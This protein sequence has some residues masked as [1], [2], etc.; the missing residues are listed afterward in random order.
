MFLSEI[1]RAL[2]R[3]WYVV[4]VGLCCTIALMALAVKVTP[5]EYSVAAETLLLPPPTSVPVGEN[6]YLSLGGLN[7]VGDILARAMEDAPAT[8]AMVAAG[9]SSEFTF[10]RDANSAAPM[11]LLTV[12]GESDAEAVRNTDVILAQ[13]PMTLK[14][15]QAR[16]KVPDNSFVTSTVVVRPEHSSVSGKNQVRA[17]VVA[18]VGGLALTLLMT[19]VVDLLMRRRAARLAMSDAWA[20]ARSE[21][22]GETERGGARSADSSESRKGSESADTSASVDGER[23]VRVTA[24][25]DQDGDD[26]GGGARERERGPLVRSVG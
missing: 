15:I 25:G 16:T 24:D 2:V 26:S 12:V 1:P 10:T 21:V 4:L 9:L 5:K 18:L 11:M 8:R 3:W 13:I 6:P 23:P 17:V 7:A 14:D 19:A 22:P 20:V